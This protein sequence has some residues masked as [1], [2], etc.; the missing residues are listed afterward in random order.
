MYEGRKVWVTPEII[1]EMAAMQEHF[2]I[3]EIADMY[4]MDPH[5]IRFYLKQAGV[6]IPSRL[7]RAEV[8]KRNKKE[9]DD[10]WA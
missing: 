4:C 6:F 8:R 5:Q 1:A 2:R 10:E 9:D 3:G 7:K